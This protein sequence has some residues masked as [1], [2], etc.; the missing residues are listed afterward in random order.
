MNILFICDEYPPGKNGGIGTV[1]QNLGRELVKQGH[2]I[3]VVGLYHFSY[4]EKN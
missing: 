3:F 4:G 1:V 2:S